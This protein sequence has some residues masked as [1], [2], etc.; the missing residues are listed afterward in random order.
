MYK[1][2]YAPGSASLAVHALLIEL[3]VPYTI[4][5]VDLQ[6]PQRDPQYL[7]LN[8]HGTVP[9]VLIG[10]EPIVESGALMIALAERHPDARMAPASGSVERAKW[11]Q[12]SVYLPVALG[13]VFRLWFYPAELGGDTDH[14][15]AVSAGLQAKLARAFDSIDAHLEAHGPYL[16]GDAFSS[17]D[18]QLMMYMRWSRNMPRPATTWPALNRFAELVKE[19][20]S[21]KQMN[22]AEDLS[23]WL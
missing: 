22:Q 11:Q 1:L 12:W 4:E 14:T 18:L 16:L 8:P 20:P 23:G 19:R 9:T 17:A 21:W 15:P 10:G 7:R 3:G 13:A 6:T 5:R 2:Y